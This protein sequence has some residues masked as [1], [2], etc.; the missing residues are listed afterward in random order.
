MPQGR[1]LVRLLHDTVTYRTAY[2][3]RMQIRNQMSMA[4]FDARLSVHT[5]ADVLYA[6]DTRSGGKRRVGAPDKTMAQ[7]RSA[8]RAEW[9]V[10]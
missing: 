2:R 7:L 1:H 10:G 3:I 4:D 8:T 6:R 9:I 5:A